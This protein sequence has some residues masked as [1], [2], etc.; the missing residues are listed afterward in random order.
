VHKDHGRADFNP[1]LSDKE[2]DVAVRI[3]RE[4]FDQDRPKL[5]VGSSLGEA[6][7]MN[8]NSGA[9][10]LVSHCTAWKRWGTVKN[11][12][13]GTA[14]LHAEADDAIRIADS[15]DMVRV[16]WPPGS[17]LI[18]VGADRPLGTTRSPGNKGESRCRL[19]TPF[20]LRAFI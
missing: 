13:P 14:I 16:G 12:K 20:A 4:E 8:L 7:A 11:L 19:K 18:V 15:W 5:V 2:F 1:R 10:R 6:E 3:A 17:S 9:A